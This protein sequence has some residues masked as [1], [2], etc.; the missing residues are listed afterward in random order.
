M[1]RDPAD[2]RLSWFRHVRRVFSKFNKREAF[3]AHFQLDDFSQVSQYAKHSSYS[4][5]V[6]SSLDYENY[7]GEVIKE[8]FEEENSH[9]LVI[10]YE[11]LLADPHAVI[12]K[13]AHRTGFLTSP[14]NHNKSSKNQDDDI[15]PE[16]E[17]DQEEFISRIV[18]TI[19]KDEGYPKTFIHPDDTKRIGSS[20]QGR[21][22]FSNRA[23]HRFDT[24]WKDVVTP[25]TKGR[26]NNYEHLQY[27]T[28]DI[29]GKETPKDTGLNSTT[30]SSVGSGSRP[31]SLL[32]PTTF[33]KTLSKSISTAARRGRGESAPQFKNNP[34]PH[35]QQQQQ[36]QPILG[37]A[38]PTLEHHTEHNRGG[39][40]SIVENHPQHPYRP[41][42]SSQEEQQHGDPQ[43]EA[44]RTRGSSL[45]FFSTSLTGS[46]SNGSKDLQQQNNHGPFVTGMM[47]PVASAKSRS[48]TFS[49]RMSSMSTPTVAKLPIDPDDSYDE[50][51]DSESG[52]VILRAARGTASYNNNNKKSNTTTTNP[53]MKKKSEVSRFFGE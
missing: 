4:S 30:S 19:T 11:E 40:R 53:K 23:L 35:D 9:I 26:F 17:E 2:V 20:R 16:Q 22:Q 28:S 18:N 45:S 42:L 34:P 39:I 32:S 48:N 49:S 12:R 43:P 14:N 52:G 36:Q 24:K 50:D 37:T 47:D 1:L 13:L 33:V 41:P 27:M 25:H 6:E 10:Y 44:R 15:S 3:D 5:H 46:R 21:I 29:L 8:A 31:S 38:N 51:E 7:I